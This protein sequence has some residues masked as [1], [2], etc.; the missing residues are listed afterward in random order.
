M[1]KID[2][3]APAKINLTLD[4]LHRRQ[5]GYH[6]LEMIMQTIKL[7]DRVSVRVIPEQAIQIFTDHIK[8]PIDGRNIAYKAAKMMIDEFKIDSG[9]KITLHKKIPVAAGLAG[10]SSNAAAVIMAVNELFELKKT[11]DELMVLGKRIGADVPFCIQRGTALATGIGEK[12]E[13]LNKIP[14]LSLL[15]VKPPYAVSTKEVYSRLDISHIKQRPKT[16]AMIESIARQDVGGIA[17][18]LCNVLE[19]VTLE[20]HPELKEIKKTLIQKGAMGSLMSGSGPTI[21]GIFENKVKAMKAAEEINWGKN[22]CLVSEV[23]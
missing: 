19:E 10:G 20:L 8:L 11:K 7:K 1:Q 21:F 14:K 4:V 22:Y 18:H 6:E 23:N 12:L 13:V 2:L 15:L 5:D 16:K 17:T 3:D 9:L